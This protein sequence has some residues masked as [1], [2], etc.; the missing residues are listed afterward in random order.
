MRGT[1]VLRGA[2]TEV[3]AMLNGERQHARRGD[4]PG[5]RQGS[6][7]AG[8]QSIHSPVGDNT[9]QRQTKKTEVSSLTISNRKLFGY[10]QHT[11]VRPTLIK[12]GMESIQPVTSSTVSERVTRTLQTGSQAER[13]TSRNTPERDRT[14]VLS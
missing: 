5:R 2:C 14:H 6:Q 7:G 13:W 11:L 3:G 12:N 9:R 10:S 4:S 1:L 8:V